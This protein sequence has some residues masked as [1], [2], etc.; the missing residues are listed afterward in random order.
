MIE[1]NLA[2]NGDI[3]VECGS[4]TDTYR[5]EFEHSGSPFWEIYVGQYVLLMIQHTMS[6]HHG[7]ADVRERGE[8]WEHNQARK[9]DAAYTATDL[10]AM[11]SG[12]NSPGDTWLARAKERD[13]RRQTC[14]C[15]AVERKWSHHRSWCATMREVQ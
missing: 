1:V 5:V 15:G 11:W 4:C 6:K 14:N 13:A 3:L 10:A 8:S 9:H 2:E 12:D 7:P